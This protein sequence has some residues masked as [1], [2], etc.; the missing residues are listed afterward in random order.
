MMKGN[1]KAMIPLMREK[2]TLL[3]EEIGSITKE[4]Y[5]KVSSAPLREKRIFGLMTAHQVG[6]I[7]NLQISFT[8]DE[9]NFNKDTYLFKTISQDGISVDIDKEIYKQ[10]GINEYERADISM[11]EDDHLIEPGTINQIEIFHKYLMSDLFKRHK[12]IQYDTCL[13][14]ENSKKT[15]KYYIIP[16]KLDKSCKD[17]NQ[18]KYKIDNQM[19][20]K[21]EKLCENGYKNEQ[22][23]IIDYLN[24]KGLVTDEERRKKLDKIILV[25]EDKPSNCYTFHKVLENLKEMPAEVVASA[26]R[27]KPENLNC[28]TGFELLYEAP[29][30][31]NCIKSFRSL[32]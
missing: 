8:E 21:V 4:K 26:I 22:E 23:K 10:N 19:L 29:T 31:F 9:Q 15:K 2:F 18:L 16:L 14:E 5:K 7:P 28:K 13:N 6:H 24:T 32:L 11:E 1:V 27:G 25:K 20:E 3:Y 30:R 12:D 17:P